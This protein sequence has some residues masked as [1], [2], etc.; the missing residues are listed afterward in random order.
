M[1]AFDKHGA[2]LV[3]AQKLAA[4]GSQVDP[5][6]FRVFAD[7]EMG[8]AHITSADLRIPLRH[9]ELEKIDIINV[10]YVC[11]GFTLTLFHF[12]GIPT[13]FVGGNVD[14]WIQHRRKL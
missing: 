5:A 12:K 13:I 6:G 10:Q 14:E 9:R 8:R 11:L 3:F 1:L 2:Q 7:D 4:I